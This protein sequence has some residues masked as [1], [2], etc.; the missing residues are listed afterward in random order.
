M[1]RT[2]LVDD[3][4]LSVVALKSKSAVVLSTSGSTVVPLISGW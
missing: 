1:L 2:G 3:E 4:V